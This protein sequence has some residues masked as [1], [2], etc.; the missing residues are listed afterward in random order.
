MAL[1]EQQKAE[2]HAARLVRDRA[3]SAR[4]REYRQAQEAAENSADVVQAHD[5]YTE[6][7]K[8]SELRNEWRQRQAKEL[9]AQIAVLQEQLNA[10]DNDPEQEALR[11]KRRAAA[12]AW[13]SS[14]RSSL[15]AVDAQFPDLKGHAQFSAAAWEPPAAVLAEM[16]AARRSAKPQAPKAK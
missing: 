8:A 5:L 12:D 15:G 11:I 3:H 14:K 7:D 10:L 6:A 4:V 16:E 2:N 1:T 13:Q 9:L